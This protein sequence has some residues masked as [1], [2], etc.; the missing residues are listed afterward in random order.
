MS[1]RVSTPPSTL[2]HLISID[3][4][5][6]FHAPL[7]LRLDST[8]PT[9]LGLSL[10]RAH[11]ALRALCR[12]PKNHLFDLQQG[13]HEGHDYHIYE[14]GSGGCCDC[15][16]SNAIAVEGWCSKHQCVSDSGAASGASSVGDAY[17]GLTPAV[18]ERIVLLL[19][20]AIRRL[21]DTLAGGQLIN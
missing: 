14:S 18:Q 19:A 3:P 5:V 21:Q 20:I 7:L 17:G 12:I 10:S 16:D 1:S 6:L 11:V 4:P 2:R 8:Q 15:G 9:K 13:N